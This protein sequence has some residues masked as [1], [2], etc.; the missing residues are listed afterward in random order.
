MRSMA[1]NNKKA[2]DILTSSYYLTV[3][4]LDSLDIKRIIS[5]AII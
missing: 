4:E 3:K 1:V 2:I 5:P